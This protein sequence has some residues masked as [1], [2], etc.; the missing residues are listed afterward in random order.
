MLIL[1]L[2]YVSAQRLEAGQALAVASNGKWAMVYKRDADFNGALAEAIALCKARG[3]TDPTIVWSQRSN[4]RN[5]KPS[6]NHGLPM[7]YRAHGAIAISDNGTGT[8]VGWCFNRTPH[9]GTIAVKDC[10]KKGG[11][12]PK[13][14]AGF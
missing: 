12:N 10:Q 6:A 1:G 13:I 4:V 5:T 9:N 3:G 8:I 14:V 7:Y 2:S 11:Q